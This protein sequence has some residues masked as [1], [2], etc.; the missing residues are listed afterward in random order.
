MRN[1]LFDLLLSFLLTTKIKRV[2]FVESVVP[3]TE[4]CCGPNMLQITL[5]VKWFWE[6]KSS[7][8]CC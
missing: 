4:E 7:L 5:E 2:E 6:K 8:G 3:S 1:R